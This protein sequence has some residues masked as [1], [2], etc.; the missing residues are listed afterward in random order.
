M[1]QLFTKILNGFKGSIIPLLMQSCSQ[2]YSG[3]A[4]LQQEYLNCSKMKWLGLC[5]TIEH[6]S[7]CAEKEVAFLN[8][9]RGHTDAGVTQASWARL[10]P[11]M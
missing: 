5:H 11:L 9:P 3:L 2:S 8:G 7:T 6:R 4:K 1:D 10:A